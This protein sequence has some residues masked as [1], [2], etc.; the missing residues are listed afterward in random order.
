MTV[1]GRGWAG[2]SLGKLQRAQ[3]AHGGGTGHYTNMCWTWMESKGIKL[4]KKQQALRDKAAKGDR[5]DQR[6]TNNPKHGGGASKH[7]P[8]AGGGKKLPKG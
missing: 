8:A 3:C 2:T 5:P 1:M 6:N 4:N 7:A